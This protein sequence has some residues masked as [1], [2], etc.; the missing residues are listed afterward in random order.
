MING[1]E[2]EA[3][4]TEKI[5]TD[6]LLCLHNMPPFIFISGLTTRFE[7]HRL[8][9]WQID[10]SSSLKHLENASNHQLSKQSDIGGKGSGD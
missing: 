7:D 3:S 9:A 8:A 1:M 6:L 5:K 2:I 10:K 4:Y